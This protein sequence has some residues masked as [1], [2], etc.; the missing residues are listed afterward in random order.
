[1]ITVKEIADKAGVSMTTVYNVLHGNVKK[2]SKANME[3]I[4]ALL[5]EHHYVQKMGLGALKNSSS[6]IIGVVIHTSRHYENTVI[7]DMFYSNVIGVMEET[8]R[9]AG[10]YMMLYSAEDLEDIFHMALAWNVDGLVAITFRY[11]NYI[12]LR[13]LVNKPIVAIDLIEKEE[14]DYVNVGLKDEEGGYLMTKYL[15]ECGYQDIRVCARK[16]VGVDHERWLGYQKA[17]KEAGITWKSNDFI[18]LSEHEEERNENYRMMMKFVNKRT[19]LFFLSDVFAVEAMHYFQSHGVVIP[20]ELGIAGFDD[21]L[22]AKYSYPRL[23]T[24]HQNVGD[25]GRKAVSLMIDMIEGRI[26]AGVDVSQPVTL[27]KGSSVKNY[28]E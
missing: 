10:Y 2:V 17:L 20:D 15:L 8:M 23:T 6:K 1:M 13:T 5:E 24:V 4:Q 16:N 11:Q 18:A 3:K 28:T 14:K 22:L 12:K 26:N 7:S 21:S 25:K 27:I 9:K 19:A